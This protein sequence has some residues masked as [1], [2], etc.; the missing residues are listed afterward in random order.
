MAYSSY[1]AKNTYSSKVKPPS[2]YQEMSKLAQYL[3]WLKVVWFHAPN[4]AKRSFRTASA[5]K[6]IGMKS[7]VPDVIILSRVPG[8]PEIRGVAI[9]MKRV[10][11]GVLSMAQSNFLNKLSEQ[12]WSTYVAN[13]FDDA[14]NWLS[15]IGIGEL[16]S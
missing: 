2:E 1:M 7:G 10:S 6:N 11:G 12:G 9:E 14:V 15:K 16:R 13:G 8:K 4:E 5:L 3:D